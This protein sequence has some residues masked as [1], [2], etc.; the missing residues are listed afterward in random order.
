MIELEKYANC[1]GIC[2]PLDIYIFTNVNEGL[3]N[4]GDCLN[5]VIE[6]LKSYS[7]TITIFCAGAIV[8]F[9]LF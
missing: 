4:K 8:F 3:P 9:V 2:S 6:Y 1:S 5:V 7:K